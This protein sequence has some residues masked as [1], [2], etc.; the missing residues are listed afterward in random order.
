MDCLALGSPV[1][2]EKIMAIIIRN[3]EGYYI[4]HE[5]NGKLKKTK[6]VSQAEDF[7]TLEKAIAQMHHNPGKTKGY[8]IVDTCTGKVCYG[9]R[10]KI[11]NNAKKQKRKKYSKTVRKMLYEKAEGRCQLC[12]RKILLSEVTIDHIIPLSLGG[13]DDE[14][15]IQV[16]CHVCNYSKN[17][18]LPD[19]FQDRVFDTL[20]YQM[21]KKYGKSLKW[22][23]VHS[24]LMKMV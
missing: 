19:E 15:N 5:M 14:S 13:I 1:E 20:C 10:K 22:K 3:R 21:E 11:K 24:L 23:L 17:S 7:E 6:E 18:Y 9:D 12:G 8:H 4:A 2:R 16:A